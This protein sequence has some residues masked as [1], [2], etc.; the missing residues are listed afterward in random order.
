MKNYRKF[1]A[2]LG[3]NANSGGKLLGV[4]KNIFAFSFFSQFFKKVFREQG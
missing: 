2:V 1:Q 3:D 4:K